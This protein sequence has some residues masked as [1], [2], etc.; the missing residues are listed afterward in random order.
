MTRR[1]GKPMRWDDEATTPT[2][3]E[4]AFVGSLDAQAAFRILVGAAHRVAMLEGPAV[5]LEALERLTAIVRMAK[6][7]TGAREP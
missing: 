5:A 6:A 3:E 1:K 7:M 2:P 4:R